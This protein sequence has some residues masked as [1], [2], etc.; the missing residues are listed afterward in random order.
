MTL[1][2]NTSS[3]TR[4][5][6]GS[7]HLVVNSRGWSPDGLLVFW[8]GHVTLGQV[9]EQQTDVV[10]AALPPSS[11]KRKGLVDYGT[12]YLVPMNPKRLLLVGCNG[13]PIKVWV[14]IHEFFGEI[15]EAKLVF[16]PA[17]VEAKLLPLNDVILWVGENRNLHGWYF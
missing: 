17:V 14:S 9:V 6:F 3:S 2:R 13:G 10:W 8:W 7:Y 1:S 11:L 4:N 5:I 15:N 16:K 12:G